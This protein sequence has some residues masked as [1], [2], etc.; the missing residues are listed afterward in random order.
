[1]KRMFYKGDRAKYNG[2]PCTVKEVNYDM[3]D[4]KYTPC[5][6][7]ILIDGKKNKKTVP[8]SDLTDGLSFLDSCNGFSHGYSNC[9]IYGLTRD[10]FLCVLTK[11][12]YYKDYFL[13]GQEEEDG[14]LTFDAYRMVPEEV[15]DIFADIPNCFVFAWWHWDGDS[16]ACTPYKTLS[17]AFDLLV[18]GDEEDE[19]LC[20]M[21]IVANEKYVFTLGAGDFTMDEIEYYNGLNKKKVLR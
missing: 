12:P 5:S 16:F 11:Y 3:A 21:T 1:M 19:Y 4:G 8:Y 17:V 15:V 2:M 18:D 14:S 6:A 9:K 20:D 10:E 7:K 13:N